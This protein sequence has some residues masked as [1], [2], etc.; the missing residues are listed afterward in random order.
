M[1]AKKNNAQSIL[2]NAYDF[3]IDALTLLGN[4]AFEF[5]MKRREMIKL[6]VAPGLKTRESQSIT[7]MPFGDE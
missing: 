3:A 1:E 7:T 4:S 5:S 6:E 2:A